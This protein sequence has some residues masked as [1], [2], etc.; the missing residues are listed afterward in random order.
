MRDDRRQMAFLGNEVYHDGVS[1]AGVRVIEAHFA[2]F[3]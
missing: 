1:L 3:L 2:V